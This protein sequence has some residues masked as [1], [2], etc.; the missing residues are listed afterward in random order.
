MLSR[1]C[2]RAGSCSELAASYDQP[3]RRSTC[4]LGRH[5][6][7]ALTHHASC[8]LLTA[9]PAAAAAS[10]TAHPPRSQS[11]QAGSSSERSEAVAVGTWSMEAAIYS[12]PDLRPLFKE[13]LPTDVIPRRW[14][15]QGGR[16]GRLFLSGG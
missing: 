7:P 9:F 6:R 15:V 14:A 4:Q 11:P 12:L 8:P 2:C 13:A 10:A 16:A 3:G 1:H 5:C